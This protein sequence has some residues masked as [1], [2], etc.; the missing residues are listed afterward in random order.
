MKTLSLTLIAF[1]TVVVFSSKS[2]AD[3]ELNKSD[4]LNSIRTIQLIEEDKSIDL[5]F[6][7]F[8]KTHFKVVLFNENGEFMKVLDEGLH[9]AN[10]YTYHINKRNLP[11]GNYVC[12]IE[13]K[14]GV[15]SRFFEVK[16]RKSVQI[17][18]VD[19]NVEKNELAIQCHFKAQD[20]VIN[21]FKEDGSFLKTIYVQEQSGSGKVKIDVSECPCGDYFIHVETGFDIYSETVQLKSTK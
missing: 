7:I 16:K 3:G 6:N 20:Y 14:H 9:Y 10:H 13:T 11:Q 2:L 4:D 21:L 17:I 1:L 15:V 18:Q 8:E 5:S 12:F 19:Y